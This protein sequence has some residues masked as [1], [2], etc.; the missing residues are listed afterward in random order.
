[1]IHRPERL[2]DLMELSRRCGLEPKKL[3]MIVPHKGEAAN[4][5][6]IQFVK[7]G[8]KGLAVLPELAVRSG[9]GGFTE[10]IDRIYG[11]TAV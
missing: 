10:D 2:A 5:V 9:S 6:L 7:A 4:M 11:R 3:R 8:G 1:M